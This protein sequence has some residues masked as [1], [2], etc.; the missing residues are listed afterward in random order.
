MPRRTKTK[1]PVTK[2][3]LQPR[4]IET[5]YVKECLKKN[6]EQ[7]ATNYNRT[8]KRLQPLQGG[9][10]VRVQS[11]DGFKKSG[12]HVCKAEH[13]QSYIVESGDREYRR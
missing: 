12:V 8:A 1:F 3:Q 13:P 2:D 6:Q 5:K 11:K 9:D 7:Q 4:S 10:V